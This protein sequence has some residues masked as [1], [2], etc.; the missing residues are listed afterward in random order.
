MD[1]ELKNQ[2]GAALT[3]TINGQQ[4]SIK[5]LRLREI[6][7]L[8]NYN[9]KEDRG[10]LDMS[11]YNI[12]LHLRENINVNDIMDWLLDLPQNESGAELKRIREA[13]DSLYPPEPETAETETP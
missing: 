4:C 2:T 10:N 11:L 5:P 3:V 1:K 12:R 8:D 9:I 6:V 13:I 7:L